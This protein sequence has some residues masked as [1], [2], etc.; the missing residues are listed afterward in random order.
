[1][2]KQSRQTGIT[3]DMRT[4]Q[5]P[6]MASL[7][8]SRVVMARALL[9]CL[10]FA[11]A[12]V[13]LPQRSF[14]QAQT[15]V[16]NRAASAETGTGELEISMSQ[17]EGFARLVLTF[18]GRNLLPGYTIKQD[19]SIFVVRFDERMDANS[20]SSMP[21]LLGDYVTIARLDPDGKG[22]RI[23]LKEG[24]RIN[25]M[26]AGERLY[27]DLLPSTWTGPPP[28]LPPEVV[29]E[30]AKRAEEALR[31]ARS[32]EQ[33]D[34]ATRIKPKLD[35]RVGDHPT[36]SRFAFIWNIPF[37]STFERQGNVVDLYFNHK[38]D[39]DLSDLRANLP[40]LVHDLVMTY[41]DGQTR[42]RLIVDKEADVRAFRED[43][44]YVVDVTGDKQLF[45]AKGVEDTITRAV[46]KP[47][48][49]GV[50]IAKGIDL[51]P[52]NG[53]EGE[54]AGVGGRIGGS[55]EKAQDLIL[56]PN[57]SGR[58]AEGTLFTNS[59]L[60]EPLM[61]N[62]DPVAAVT[63]VAQTRMPFDVQPLPQPKP[64]QLEADPSPLLDP[65]N[66]QAIPP[67]QD[68]PPAREQAVTPTDEA[69]GEASQLVAQASPQS[70]DQMSDVIDP[71][72]ITMETPLE[73]I[74]MADP[75]LQRG[76]EQPSNISQQS[77]EIVP[78][79][80]ERG[81]AE[82]MKGAGPDLSSQT[83]RVEAKQ[84]G[85]S[86]RLYFPFKN[87]TGSAVFK[88]NGVIWAVFDTSLDLDVEGCAPTAH[89]D[90]R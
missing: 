41:E 75:G 70:A 38:T 83:L 42:F 43:S 25:T 71:E 62:G 12:A 11:V 29:M 3:Q 84:F 86:V 7:A 58:N 1:M 60:T 49:T 23:A 52:D 18:V 61:P 32:L 78:Q 19:N 76:D 46:S 14:A 17:Q 48:D 15:T 73:A 66:A 77:R 9:T 39:A 63:T 68:L 34:N 64:E 87:P 88:R 13:S 54:V 10:L 59:Q 81:N 80:V 27:V 57:P 74:D 44:S 6:A 37:D 90:G 20:V 47:G 36:F 21:R 55:S 89:V 53:N 8:F 67:R 40:P 51:S 2:S 56:G 79:Q 82:L 22:M 65:A 4:A 69:P 31:L 72:S 5:V 45:E 35:I 28:V 85:R 50:L 16:V 26:E 24:I 33:S 30:L